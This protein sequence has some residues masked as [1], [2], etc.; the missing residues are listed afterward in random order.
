MLSK[1]SKL[2]L[3]LLSISILVLLT[4]STLAASYQGEHHFLACKNEMPLPHE[5]ELTTVLTVNTGDGIGDPIIT[6]RSGSW[7]FWTYVHW[8]WWPF[9]YVENRF[10][11]TV[12]WTLEYNQF[13]ELI[14]VTYRVWGKAYRSDNI[15]AYVMISLWIR[16]NA[17]GHETSG[18]SYWDDHL[19]FIYFYPFP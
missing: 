9:W 18:G 16:I 14:A 19:G 12:E 7:S 3:I 6:S 2:G 13:N 4:P 1:R 15:N 10:G 17:N 5:F 11:G 8:I